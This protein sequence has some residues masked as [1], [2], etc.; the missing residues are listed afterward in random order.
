VSKPFEYAVL[1]VVPRVERGEFINAG[2]VLYCR[3][4][5][6]LGARVHLDSDRLMALDPGTDLAAVRAHLEAVRSVCAGGPEAGSV[7]RLPLGER[8]GWLVAPRSTVVQPSPVHTGLT[9]DPEAELERLLSRMVLPPGQDPG[10][11]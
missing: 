8:F 1:R 7:G 6:F 9:D 5:S 10:V 11:A 2:V 4:D 3:A